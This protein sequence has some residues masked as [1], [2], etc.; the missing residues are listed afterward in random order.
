MERHILLGLARFVH[1]PAA[2]EAGFFRREIADAAFGYQ[3][4]IDA[5][6][7]LIVGVNAFQETE[8]KPLETLQIDDA[9]EKEQRARV[10]RAADERVNLA[11]R[12]RE[13]GAGQ[14]LTRCVH[15]SDQRS[16]DRPVPSRTARQRAVLPAG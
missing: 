4:E 12:Q 2:I 8:A 9:V 15:K 10:D 7:K 5:N 13:R 6:R 1:E 11:E 16:S 14:P 3:R